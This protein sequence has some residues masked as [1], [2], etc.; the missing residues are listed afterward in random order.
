M[1]KFKE[2]SHPTEAK[3]VKALRHLKGHSSLF[4]SSAVCMIRMHF[5][6]MSNF[7]TGK[8]ILS[9]SIH[10]WQP[11]LQGCT[12]QTAQ[13]AKGWHLLAKACC[14]RKCLEL[15]DVR[16]IPK[17]QQFM[18]WGESGKVHGLRMWEKK[19]RAEQGEGDGLDNPTVIP[20]V[21]PSGRGLIPLFYKSA[22]GD[23]RPLG[24]ASLLS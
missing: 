9:C 1:I 14:H 4:S 23:K 24:K 6:E 16:N 13:E 7:K 10:S 5:Q 18:K 21:F 19:G 8:L 22:S 11:L 3:Q 17:H 12:E 15:W 20:T 2:E